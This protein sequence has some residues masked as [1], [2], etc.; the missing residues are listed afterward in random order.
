MTTRVTYVF[1][2]EGSVAFGISSHSV[3]VHC[4]TAPISYG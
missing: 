1:R 4:L 3:S 2:T